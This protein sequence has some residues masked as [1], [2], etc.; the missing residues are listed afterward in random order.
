MVDAER[1]MEG[2]S[3]C[4]QRDFEQ[5][6]SRKSWIPSYSSAETRTLTP[7]T[8]PISVHALCEQL[9]R[10]AETMVTSVATARCE[11]RLKATPS[12]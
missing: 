9:A 6:S 8:D 5:T 12:A 11:T 4:Q 3:R 10:E 2:T 7:D 1:S